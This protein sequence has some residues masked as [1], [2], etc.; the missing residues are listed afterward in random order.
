MV[1]VELR[2]AMLEHQKAMLERP[3]QLMYS[4]RMGT[5]LEQQT[6]MLGRRAVKLLVL[7]M[8]TEL[9]T[10]LQTA[11][12]PRTATRLP[13]PQRATRLLVPRTVIV[14]QMVRQQRETWLALLEQGR[15]A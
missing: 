1:M 8:V 3:S 10:L 2:T 9:L 4:L 14:Q 12:R 6:G 11:R 5:L 7:Q 15:W 13:V